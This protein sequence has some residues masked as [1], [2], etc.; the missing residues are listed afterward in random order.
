MTALA[1]PEDLS[2]HPVA[3]GRTGAFSLE[4]VSMTKV[5]G[6]LVAL[7]DVSIKVGAGEFA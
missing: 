1:L 4:T 5:F 3:G 6:S 2:S 7:D